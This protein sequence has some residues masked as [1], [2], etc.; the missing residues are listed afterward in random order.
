MYTLKPEATN[1]WKIVEAA[2]PAYLPKT[3][4]KSTVRGIDMKTA[5]ARTINKG[6]IHQVTKRILY[7]YETNRGTTVRTP[8]RQNRQRTESRESEERN[9]RIEADLEIEI[10]NTNTIEAS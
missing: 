1:E 8:R 10:E 4:K 2:L 7:Y 6:K 9:N 3:M 5:I